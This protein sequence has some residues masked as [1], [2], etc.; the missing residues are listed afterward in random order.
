MRNTALLTVALSL[1]TSIPAFALPRNR[2]M[3]CQQW[4]SAEKFIR[5]RIIR[6]A[7]GSLRA[8]FNE[9]DPINMNAQTVGVR[10][11]DEQGDYSTHY[12]SIK[13]SAS[14]ESLR[15]SVT[16][17]DDDAEESIS[18]IDGEV[19]VGHPATAV[20]VLDFDRAD[21]T[22]YRHTTRANHLVCQGDVNNG[23]SNE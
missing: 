10:L 9:G 13:P 12:E 6:K 22:H 11:S 5:I 8:S 17:M 7:D 4:V 14:I 15:L 3:E 16:A 21:G 1:L 18:P 19:F 23:T 2:V 20:V